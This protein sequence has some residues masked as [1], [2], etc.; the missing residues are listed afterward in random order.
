MR[1]INYL[2]YKL[3]E[4]DKLL[5]KISPKHSSQECVECGHIAAENR[6]THVLLGNSIL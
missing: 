6:K 4:R 5:V 2:E 1:V 3:R